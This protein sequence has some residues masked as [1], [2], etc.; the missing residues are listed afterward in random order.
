[1]FSTNSITKAPNKCILE[2]RPGLLVKRYQQWR[3]LKEDCRC[4]HRYL[5]RDTCYEVTVFPILS[6]LSSHFPWERSA[7]VIANTFHTTGMPSV[8]S[9]PS[10]LQKSAFQVK[11]TDDLNS[12]RKVWP[13]KATF[14]RYLVSHRETDIWKG[15][16]AS[17]LPAKP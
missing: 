15:D 13:K 1:M 17:F 9:S 4:T 8:N 12:P 6:L 7:L 14:F 16:K 5:C 11:S 2:I 10:T 3:P